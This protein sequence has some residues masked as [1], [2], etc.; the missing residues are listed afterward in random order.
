MRRNMFNNNEVNMMSNKITVHI[1]SDNAR[2][3]SMNNYDIKS[4]FIER[5]V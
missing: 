4:Y 1:E 2:S 3:K 5:D